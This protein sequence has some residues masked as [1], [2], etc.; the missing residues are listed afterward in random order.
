[1]SLRER[2]GGWRGEPF[3]SE[4]RSHVSVYTKP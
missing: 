3:S 2:L 4:S 1:M